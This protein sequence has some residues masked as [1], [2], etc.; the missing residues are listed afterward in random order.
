MEYVVTAEQM[1]MH[2]RFV[3]EQIGVSAELLME[4]AALFAAGVIKK[5]V[6][7]DARI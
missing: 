3:M 5:R 7:K 4:R 6:K 1:R 2:E